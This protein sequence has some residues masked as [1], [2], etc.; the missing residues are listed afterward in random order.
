MR[1]GVLFLVLL[2]ISVVVV[3]RVRNKTLLVV[4]CARSGTT[5]IADVLTKGGLDIGHEKM[6][7]DGISSWDLAVKTSKGRWRQYPQLYRF[8][9]IFHQV[10]DPLEVISSV[11]ETENSKSWIYILAHMPEVDMRDSHLVKC[12]KYWYYWNLEAEKKAEWTYRVEDFNNRWDEFQRRVGKEIAFH[13]IPKNINGREGHPHFTW[14]DLEAELEPELLA[15]IKTMAQR[16]G[17]TTE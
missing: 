4:G 14:K 17:Y 9:H 2:V 12:A 13:E 8:A 7:L 5:Y 3:H 10:R 15:N 16:Y 1:I 11:Y 6:G